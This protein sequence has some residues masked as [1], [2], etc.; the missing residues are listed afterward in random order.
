MYYNDHS[1]AHF[2]A[3]YGNSRVVVSIEPLGVLQGR[4]PTRSEKML[5]EWARINQVELQLA[6]NR[7]RNDLPPGKIAPLD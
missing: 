1:P 6:W 4:L 2:H 7:A 3:R 5:L